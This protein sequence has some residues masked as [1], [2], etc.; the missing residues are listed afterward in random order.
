MSGPDYEDEYREYGG[1]Y[2]MKKLWKEFG[3]LSSDCYINIGKADMTQ[4][5]QAFDTLIRAIEETRSIDPDFAK[6][7]FEV[8]EQTD[9]E[10]GVDDWLLDYL[11]ELGMRKLN[12]KCCEVCEKV[13]GLFAWKEQ[14]PEDFVF[15]MSSALSDQGKTKEAVAL[16]EK[17]HKEEPESQPLAAALIYAM[18]SAGDDTGAE[19]VVQKYISKEDEC[20][21]DTELI[22]RAAV[23]LYEAKGDKKTAKQMK[24]TLEQYEEEVE[25]ELMEE[26]EELPFGDEDEFDDLF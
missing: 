3:R 18:I 10:Y 11:D 4:W 24:K 19:E 15:E 6:E 20:T 13:I 7:F 21:E 12:E 22:Y 14:S 25:R 2:I 1:R 16:C 8:D 5:H 23:R 26:F 9:F 17:W